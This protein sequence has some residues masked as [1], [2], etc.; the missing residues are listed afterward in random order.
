MKAN[1]AIQSRVLDAIQPQRLLDTAT[2]LVA[3]PSPTGNA[4]AVL[5]CLANVLT[6]DGFKV[7]RPAADYPQAPAVA[8]R[9]PSEP[10]RGKTLQFNGHLDTV[11]LPFVPPRV[12][13]DLLRGSGSSDM[14]AGTAAA[15]EALRALRDAG[16]LEA[17]AILFTAHDLQESPRGDGSQLD[18]RITDG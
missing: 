8:V 9:W 2:K 3:V 11:H 16:G 13:G 18:R 15:V 1:L 10:R 17:G 4:K 12:E 5:D 7:E 6:A 14:K